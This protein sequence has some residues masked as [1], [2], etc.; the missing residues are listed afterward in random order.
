MEKGGQIGQIGCRF[1][2]LGGDDFAVIK[3]KCA[4]HLSAVASQMPH[5]TAL[6]KR[7]ERQPQDLG[8]GEFGKPALAETK[9]TIESA[10]RIGDPRDIAVIGEI[11]DFVAG[12]Q[13]VDENQFRIA[14]AGSLVGFLKAFQDLPGERA[15][16]VAEENQNQFAVLRRFGQSRT[17]GESEFRC[18]RS[19]P[20]PIPE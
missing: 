11:L 17:S 12:F 3:E 20:G 6:E 9:S 2:P 14:G 16:E 5:S 13:H 4:G 18:S 7:N 19:K 15:A 8:A 1:G 10:M